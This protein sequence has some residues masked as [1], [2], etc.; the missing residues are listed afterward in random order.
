MPS[1][2]SRHL[3]RQRALASACW[4]IYIVY[5]DILWYI[6]IHNYLYIYICV[7]IYI[8]III[9]YIYV[10]VYISYWWWDYMG[11]NGYRTSIAIYSHIAYI[12]YIS[13]SALYVFRNTRYGIPFLHIFSIQWLNPYVLRQIHASWLLKSVESSSTSINSLVIDK[14]TYYYQ[15]I[16]VMNIDNS[17]NNTLILI[18]QYIYIW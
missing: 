16:L 15:H 14:H 11:Y 5:I 9:I 18:Y 3:A 1:G 12:I 2:T 10:Y 8:Y 13:G 7:Y 17:P 6:C 4:K